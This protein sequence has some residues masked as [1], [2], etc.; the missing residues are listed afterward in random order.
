MKKTY[1]LSVILL[2]AILLTACA[3][4]PMGVKNSPP[5]VKNKIID[6]IG[7]SALSTYKQYPRTQQILLAVRG[8]KLDAYRNLAEEVHGVRIKGN[9]T[10]KD[11]ITENDSYRAFVD[12]V[13][14]GA[15]V[16][17]ITPK[18]NGIYEAEVSLTLTPKLTHCLYFHSSMCY[19]STPQSYQ[20]GY[21]VEP[22]KS[23]STA[24]Y[25]RTYRTESKGFFS[26]LFD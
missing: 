21:Q 24:P 6:T 11:M 4:I 2:L 25:Y 5:P 1:L 18:A 15:H 20:S 9:T 13:V 7:Y 17:A 3:P 23:E 8:A 26:W 12:S 10:V 16:T 14:R 19:D 22:G